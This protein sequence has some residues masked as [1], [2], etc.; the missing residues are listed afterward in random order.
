M[1]F[2]HIARIVAAIMLVIGI[3]MVSGAFYITTGALGP[4]QE[5]V[6]QYW[7]GKTTGQVIDRGIYLVFIAIALGTLAEISFAV[8]G[9]FKKREQ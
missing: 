9:D 6:Q 1:V 5:A 2:S 4:P 8:R 7:P 3:G